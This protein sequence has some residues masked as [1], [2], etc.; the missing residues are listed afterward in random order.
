MEGGARVAVRHGILGLLA[1]RPRHGYELKQE[2]DLLTGRLWELNIGQIYS[3][4]DRMVK[5]GL[6]ALEA[7]EESAERKVYRVTAAGLA[8]LQ[9]WLERPPA[10]PRPL[11]DEVF[12]RLG[13]LVQRDLADALDLVQAQRR[14]YHQQMAEL[15]R[16]KIGLARGGPTPERL[17]QELLLDAAL[18]HTEADLKW[19][20]SC[21]ARV[22]AFLARQ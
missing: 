3:T 5:E 16:Q 14:I 22:R 11:R 12:V 21:E 15:T 19:L 7:G 6:V 2:F 1:E 13:L 20:D 9:T 8:E 17:R 4:L 18:L 10:K